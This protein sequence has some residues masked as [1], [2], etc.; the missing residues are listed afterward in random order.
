M[1]LKPIEIRDFTAGRFVVEPSCA[2][3]PVTGLT[4][5]SRDVMRGDL[6]VALPG[7]RVDGH[8]FAAAA[9][10]G[11]AVGVLASHALEE[12]VLADVRAAE[13]FVIEVP[14][15]ARAVRDLACGWRGLLH[16]RVVGVTGS[17]GKTST[18]NLVRD[19]LSARFATVATKANQNNELGVPKTVLS[20]EADTEAVVVEMGMRGQGQI[21]ELCSFVRPH[22][23]LITNV[24]E[25]H[26]ELLGSRENIAR[27]K[28]EL[29]EA[30][31]NG[32]GVAVLNAADEFTP[33][34]REVARTDARGIDVLLYDGSGAP[35]PDAAVF[36]TDVE[37]DG[38]GRPRFM[39]HAGGASCPCTLPVFGLHNV[40]NAC[41][42]AAVG[43][44]FG[45]GVEE[46]AA[47]LAEAQAE[48]GR[49]EVLRAPGGWTV[50]NDAYNAN[51][52]SMKAA[53]AYFAALSVEGRR[54]A[55]LG[56]MGELGSFAV[57]GHKRV[58]AMAAQAGLD[59]L[60]CVG[61]LS[62]AMADAARQAGMD[63]AAVSW[64][65]SRDEALDAVRAVVAPGDAVLVK[66]SHFMGLERL[67][68]G[69][70]K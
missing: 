49:Q 34:V 23:G 64:V 47:A 44:A 54:I 39:L 19:V 55:V 14:D 32:S 29:I 40:H 70:V 56:D 18:K 46:I 59:A 11:G 37:L 3:M 13:G 45:M 30:L 20:A 36:A 57:D 9:I 12:S 63:D 58:G 21:E 41:A 53:L 31:P 6:Y 52:D 66:A 22:V 8:D 50:V 17:T 48:G 15:T 28:A 43:V 24:G 4:W 42:A 10:K 27:A 33:F 38:E 68:E 26:I 67:A 65:A 16:G 25:S 61:E 35:A 51:P 62:R 60:V 69:L 1:R 7:E 2:D 5:D